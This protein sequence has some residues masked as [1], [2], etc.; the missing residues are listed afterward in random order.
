MKINHQ[1]I[2]E[3]IID[4]IDGELNTED[5]QQVEAFIAA[6]PEYHSMLATYQ[7][8]IISISEGDTDIKFDKSVLYH[9]DAQ[10][11]SKPFKLWKPAIA[12]ALL[13]GICIPFL[14]K[15]NH[16]SASSIAL[17]EIKDLQYQENIIPK[18]MPKE[19]GL[20]HKEPKEDIGIVKEKAKNTHNNINSKNRIT[21]FEELEYLEVQHEA[22]LKLEN[23]PIAITT[24]SF[25]AEIDDIVIQEKSNNEP[26][27]TLNLP[28]EDLKVEGIALAKKIIKAKD[29]LNNTAIVAKI[30]NKQIKIK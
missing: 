21:D 14:N 9:Y 27:I 30:G 11:I 7:E 20:D 18:P 2:E 25:K 8:T 10:T 6:N 17:S 16:D 24:P 19:P 15:V 3:Y 29:L 28:L 1:N 12:A 23:N 4:Y 22:L 13:I 5:Q 26:Y